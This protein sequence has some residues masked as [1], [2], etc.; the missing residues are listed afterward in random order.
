MARDSSPGPMTGIL[1]GKGQGSRPAGYGM[2]I[3]AVG[4]FGRQI[5]EKTNRPDG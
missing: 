4:L 1:A 3:K 5:E 2:G